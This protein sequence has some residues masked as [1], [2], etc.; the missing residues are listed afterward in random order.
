MQVAS[1][2]RPLAPWLLRS[3]ESDPSVA[4]FLPQ[5]KLLEGFDEILRVLIG[6]LLR[7]CFH[8]GAMHP[9]QCRLLLVPLGVCGVEYEY[10]NWV[11]KVVRLL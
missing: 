4:P 2:A 11:E 8:S 9:L 3:D 7:F 6:Q 1:G 10:S 5:N